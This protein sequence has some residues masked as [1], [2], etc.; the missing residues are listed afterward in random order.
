[1]FHLSRLIAEII[2]IIIMKKEEEEEEI[3]YIEEKTTL[4]STLSIL[5][6]LITTG[7]NSETK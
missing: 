2:I 5:S 1:M 3:M 4:R 6:G 7:N